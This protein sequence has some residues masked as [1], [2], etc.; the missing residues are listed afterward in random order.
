M[1]PPASLITPESKAFLQRWAITTL[2]VLVAANVLQG[3]SYDSPS[4]LLAATLLLGLL[5]AFV[6]PVMMLLSLPLLLFTLGL[7]TLV[8]NAGLLYFVGQLKFF[9]VDSFWTAM[10]GAFLISLITLVLNAATGLSG[11]RVRVRSSVRRRRG[12]RG[13][14]RSVGPP[15]PGQGPVIDV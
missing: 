14:G 5:N 2:A 3:I 13:P 8:I 15:P 12:P 6:K 10:K 4:G 1:P 9:H 11:G 7:F